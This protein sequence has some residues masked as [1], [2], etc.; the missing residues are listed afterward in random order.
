MQAP[1]PVMGYRIAQRKGISFKTDHLLNSVGLGWL[2]GL[3]S[4]RRILI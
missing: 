2:L 3:L 1:N 4:E